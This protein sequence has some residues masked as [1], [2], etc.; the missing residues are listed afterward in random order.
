ME[1]EV[2]G[3]AAHPSDH[4]CATVS[5]DRTCRVW[6]LTAH[7]MRALRILKKPSRSVAY[8]P[9]GRAL[10]VGFKD[11]TCKN[12][13]HIFMT[14]LSQGALLLLT[15]L[16]LRTWLVFITGK[17]IYQ[18]SS[19]RLV[20]S[21][22]VLGGGFNKHY[23]AET[24]KY[25]AVASH[26]NFVDIYNVLASKRVGVCKGASSYITHVDWNAQGK[27]NWKSLFFLTSSC[28][29]TTSD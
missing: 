24:G 26:D 16:R 15:R 8:S 4:V 19:F 17:R 27:S 9:D 6:D 14:F 29:Q 5:D 28:R 23:F 11:G 1:G 10:A 20:S 25:L 12:Q 3:L 13:R 7:R 18:I 22:Y 2:W 21:L